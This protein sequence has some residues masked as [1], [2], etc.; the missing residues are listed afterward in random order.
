MLWPTQTEWSKLTRNISRLPFFITPVAHRALLVLFY[1]YEISSRK[2]VQ[3]PH[4]HAGASNHS[5]LMLPQSL[6]KRLLGLSSD[7]IVPRLPAEGRVRHP[8]VTARVGWHQV[9][10]VGVDQPTLFVAIEA[11]HQ[12]VDRAPVLGAE[13]RSHGRDILWAHST[14]AAN[15]CASLASLSLGRSNTF[16]MWGFQKMQELRLLWISWAQYPLEERRSS[17]LRWAVKN[18][19]LVST[20]WSVQYGL[21]RRELRQY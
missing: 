7:Q 2:S 19:P 12:A 11:D 3:P 10:P 6:V 16:S 5:D 18:K 13:Q 8:P 4:P 1:Y 21:R 9:V 14:V 17:V 20:G 15:L